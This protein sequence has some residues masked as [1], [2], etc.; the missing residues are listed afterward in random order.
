MNYRD[1]GVCT[2][3]AALLVCAVL[4]T[5]VGW[6][7]T[8]A[9]SAD[10]GT[11]YAENFFKLDPDGLTSPWLGRS[12]NDVR[13]NWALDSLGIL[14]LPLQN[15]WVT[16]VDGASN[17]VLLYKLQAGDT[18]GIPIAYDFDTYRLIKAEHNTLADW[19]ESIQNQLRLRDRE[20]ARDLVAISLPFKLPKAVTS[21]VGEGGA[22]LKVNGSKRISF[23]G[24]SQWRDGAQTSLAQSQSKFPSLDMEQVTQMTITGKIGSKIEV[25]V[26]QDS[27]RVTDLSNRIQ[28]RY[29]GDED[30]IIQTIEAGNTNLALP[31]TQFVGYSQRVQGLFGLK[32]TAQVGNFNLTGIVSQEKGSTEGA[33]FTAGARGERVFKRDND[34]LR[35]R[36]FWLFD[37]FQDTVWAHY[38]GRM[39]GAT[40]ARIIDFK[41]YTTSNYEDQKADPL[42]L[43]LPRVP[44][45]LTIA[46]VRQSNQEFPFEERGVLR[47]VE[48]NDYFVERNQFWLTLNDNIPMSDATIL[49]C[50]MR[51]QMSD[52]SIVEVGKLPDTTQIKPSFDTVSMILLLLKPQ[53]PYPGD[54]TWNLEWKNVY[55]LGVRDI[56]PEGFKLDVYKGARGTENREGENENFQA[57]VPYIEILGLDRYNTNGV[58]TPDGIVD[59]NPQ[60]LDRR[61]GHLIFLNSFP[62]AP[63]GYPTP[64][65]FLGQPVR[66]FLGDTLSY[67]RNA[68]AL[69][70]QTPAIYSGKTATERQQAS[71]YYLAIS[72]TERQRSYSLG[73]ANIIE[74]SETVK[75]NGRPL[76]RGVDY[77]ISYELGQINFLSDE[78]LDPN[79]NVTVDYEYEP[80]FSVDR[81]TLFGL[82]GEYSSSPNF[83]WGATALFKSETQPDNRKPRLGEEPSRTLIWD[84]D[85]SYKRDMPI[86][87]RLTDALPL[88]EATSPSSIDIQ[89]ELAQSRPNPNTK[90]QVYVDDFE[91]SQ[92]IVSLP[93]LREAW[94]ASST[95]DSGSSGLS[96]RDRG[97]MNWYNRFDPFS[98]TEIYNRAD[99]GTDR[100]QVLS[101]VLRNSAG[102]Q[103]WGGIQRSISAGLRN[104]TNTQYLELR[105]RG[106]VG[107]LVVNLGQVSED[108][109]GDG[110]L[111]TEDKPR[112]G[113]VPNGILDDDEDVGLDGRANN[114][115]NCDSSIF[116]PVFCDP[117]DPSGDNWSYSESNKNE[118]RLIN[119]TEGNRGD[120][121]RGWI[122]DTEDL[123]GNN[124]LDIADNYF[125][126]VIDLANLDE[127]YL[128]DSSGYC[129]PP[130]GDPNLFGW[131][132]FR[133][134]LTDSILQGIRRTIKNPNLQS[135]EF[136]R[137]YVTDV[138][139]GDSS[140]IDI[141]DMNLV[142][143]RWRDIRI[144][145]A[146]PDSQD[147]KVAVVNTRE[148]AN[149]R[150]PL[151]VEG[152]KERDAAT[153]REID[154]GEQSL[155]LRFAN[156]EP[157][158]PNGIMDT[159]VRVVDDT[160][161]GAICDT[162]Q[163]IVVDTTYRD[164]VDR[165]IVGQT[166]LASQDYTGYRRMEMYVHGDENADGQI[167]FFL[168]IGSDTSNYYEYYTGVYRGQAR[169]G[170]EPGWDQRNHVNIDFNELTGLKFDVQKDVPLQDLRD[171]Y[172]DDGRHLRIRGN[173]TLSRIQFLERGIA[174]LDSANVRSGEL[175]VDELRLTEV[176]K[177]VGWA[178]RASVS[179]NFSDLG[180]FSVA[181]RRQN[182]AFQTLTAARN[183]IVNSSD[184][185]DVSIT[186]RL[187]PHKILPASWGFQLPVSVNWG[188]STNTPFFKTRSDI[189]VPADARAEEAS[190]STRK[191]ISV[192]ERFTRQTDNLIYRY[193]LIPLQLSLSY[194]QSV[195]TSPTV[196]RS[197]SKS[198][199]GQGRYELAINKPPAIPVFYWMR[200]L[201]LPSKIY[202]TRLT[203]LP[204]SFNSSGTFSQRE[205]LTQRL[206]N[207]DFTSSY[208]RDFTGQMALR[209]QPLP[210]LSADYTYNTQR[211]L[212][213]S[214][215]V[216]LTPWPSKFRLGEETS[217]NQTFRSSYTTRI[218]PF[219]EQRYQFDATYQENIERQTDRTRS[220]RWT[221]NL[222]GTY[223]LSWERLFG[224]SNKTDRWF[225]PMLYQPV[226]R[227]VRGVFNRLEPLSFTVSRQETIN[228]YG[229][230]QRPW[231]GFVF[232]FS[233]EP[234]A[235]T[236]V[237]SGI[238]Q[239]SSEGTSESYSARSGFTLLGAR[240]TTTYSQRNQTSDNSSSRT[241]TRSETFPSLRISFTDLTKLGL[242]KRF[243]NSAS[244]EFA[245]DE[246][247]DLQKNLL[248]AAVTST[249]N[250]KRFSPLVGLNLNL[251]GNVS[252]N[253]KVDHTKR[254]TAQPSAATF[255]ETKTTEDGLDL[256]LRYTFS[257]PTGIRLPLLRGIKLTSNM[258][259]TTAI[260]WTKSRSEQKVSGGA[261]QLRSERTTFTVSP[262]ASYSFSQTLTGGFRA[263]WQD[264]NDKVQK[265][266][267]HVREL[268]FWIE[269][270]F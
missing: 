138:P 126:Y 114:A 111:D 156:L 221:R 13:I 113:Q 235:D 201:L 185:E 70:P 269:F 72:T 124:T 133:V 252:T 226:R 16:K 68:L 158:V 270:R 244:I 199:S 171:V 191:G 63:T 196:F 97:K 212:R 119:G 223:G 51:I 245:Y 167:E 180:G 88:V 77:S 98:I 238:S 239:R 219:L 160:T 73:R 24:R 153:G 261:F 132:T 193:L 135:V 48:D 192:A 28:L 100:K 213:D 42:A 99:P 58:A 118:Y 197:E 228:G 139:A 147:L 41:L 179:A 4:S 121:N 248:T 232:G 64:V 65:Q 250:D 202:N 149:Y 9:P 176:R 123:N 14:R 234:R 92:E 49:A 142:S 144:E 94:T 2:V 61:R 240:I 178:A 195:N 220:I 148:N 102:S 162:V 203:L 57:D 26:D 233:R 112:A 177:D 242:I 108:V 80:F 56:N 225:T 141:A 74:G 150:S 115:E 165:V 210:T 11:A 32:S 31:N 181:Y 190:V 211:D 66:N 76:T 18:A 186:A 230:L 25:R 53:N 159:T 168:R 85:I 7:Q 214:G 194:S 174:N 151:G 86:L 30:E 134:P 34:Y 104:L 155:L 140:H 59:D 231:N 169:P 188:R 264:T 161:S 175:W 36:Y 184:A 43:C 21:I 237:T 246:K 10:S 152:V 50:Y 38:T 44:D 84:S 263:R 143:Y 172:F 60:I 67:A 268:G 215:S 20:K 166:L 46:Q 6:A 251:R 206:R 127:P 136:M 182:Y 87:T 146:V 208:S 109:D 45:T 216:N 54:P 96:A 259:L 23:S 107:K 249:T 91:A 8:S 217:F 183:N 255:S 130:C 19:H 189:V 209:Y 101:L 170:E 17:T 35:F 207:G 157:R 89:A 241:Q 52:S 224:K 254:L 29:R 106:S 256:S 103:T 62:F 110:F 145:S 229:Y 81:K 129:D 1:W 37:P 227:L 164:R 82:R 69:D 163:C 95:P 5:R 83:R 22:G 15:E 247:N 173:P 198:Y 222:Q 120:P 3:R 131:R 78:V 265:A 187:S 262:Q 218:I 47:F 204:G 27:R 236:I 137:L 75:L 266:V 257:A 260:S 93:L 33:T 122:P 200:Y 105:V 117:A 205:S 267:S 90:G 40:P 79:A 128:V 243:A 125:E 253:V 258:N 116:N 55:D 12:Y 154:Q 71:Q 39:P